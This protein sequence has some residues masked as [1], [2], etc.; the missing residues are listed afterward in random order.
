MTN[1][2]EH[3]EPND[4]RR[5]D[6]DP[7]DISPLLGRRVIHHLY[8]SSGDLLPFCGTTPGPDDD[9]DWNAA[10]DR[11]TLLQALSF[12]LPCCSTCLSPPALGGWTPLIMDDAAEQERTGA[13]PQRWWLEGDEDEILI[14]EQDDLPW[15]EP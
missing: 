2:R 13:P 6:V 8:H 5:R 15:D 9:G 3:N 10:H 14:G 1:P 7:E 4:A 12:G 11:D